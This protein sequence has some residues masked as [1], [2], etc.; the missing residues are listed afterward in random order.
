MKQL[1]LVSVFLMSAIAPMWLFANEHTFPFEPVHNGRE[2]PM[3]VKGA[4][5]ALV[6]TYS[7]RLSPSGHKVRLAISEDEGQTWRHIDSIAKLRAS[8]FGLQRRPTT[9]QTSNGTLVCTYED[10]KTSGEMPKVYMTRST[11]NGATW[12]TAVA[13][14]SGPQAPMQDFSSMAAGVDGNLVV[15]S[16]SS[17][18]T[19]SGTHIFLVRST[20]HGANWSSPIRV[21]R[22]G[23][24]GKACECC[25]TSVAIAPDG[26]VGVAFRA[27][28]SNIRDVHAA[29]S[30]DG[31]LT[32]ADP[33][34]IQDMPWTVDG[35]PS[36]GP[37]IAFD[38]NSK[39][40]ISWR[41]FRD[42]ATQAVVWY[43]S[44]LSTGTTT[45]QNVDLSSLAASDSDYPAIT[46][47]P[48]GQ[49][50]T[51]THESTNGL[52]AAVS[53]DGGNTFTSSVIDELVKQNSSVHGVSL[54]DGRVV[55]AWMSGRDG[56][57]DVAFSGLLTST[58]LQDPFQP[59][60]PKHVVG[61]LPIQGNDDVVA[62]DLSGRQIGVIIDSFGQKRA[63]P[64]C[65]GAA[66][67]AIVSSN[68]QH[69]HLVI[70]E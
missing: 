69:F 7:S 21:N 37:S 61:W 50:I 20:D 60:T 22:K 14:Y 28:R 15:V 29:F 26:T 64:D 56:S 27:N 65:R 42:G 19:E 62:Y 3:L 33:V 63:R 12:S 5:G 38:G 55:L 70:P 48:D 25:M 68:H 53:V 39:A 17:D 6:C 30:T 45:P 44:I 9:V 66:I 2:Y 32:F 47:S 43:A 16:V 34:R 52:R 4:K 46:V 40:H 31:G 51:V 57:F 35:C 24:I 49:K 10:S 1:L 13:V 54:D 41:D 67:M 11:D 36:T 23:W 58:V 59:P 18:A 8:M